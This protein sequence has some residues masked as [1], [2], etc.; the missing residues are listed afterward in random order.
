MRLQR[1]NRVLLTGSA[2]F[3]SS[4]VLTPSSSSSSNETSSFSTSSSEALSSSSSSSFSSSSAASSSVSSS[5]VSSSSL[6]EE[7]S[8]V[9]EEG[10]P[11]IFN[12]FD[13]GSSAINRAVELANISDATL[14]L[15]LYTIA[16]YRGDSSKPTYRLPLTGSL[17]AHGVYVIVSDTSEEFFK[18][19]ADLVSSMLIN[20]GTYPMILLQGEKRLDTLGFPGYQTSWGY[21]S[22][23]VRKNEFQIGRDTF[24]PD[25]WVYYA[26]DEVSHLRSYS[27]PL[28]ED[29][30][31]LGPHLDDSA[32][33]LPYIGKDGLGT[34]GVAEVTVT[35]YGDGDTTDFAY[36]SEINNAGYEDG[37]AFRYQNVDTPETQ[38]GS[39][40]QAQPWGYAA[41]DFTNGILKKA[42]HILVQSIAG[43]ELTET[44]GR[45]LGFVWTSEVSHPSAKDYIL[46]NHEIVVNGYSKVAFSGVATSQMVSNGLSYYSYLLDGNNHAARL[47]LKV[48]GE[49]DP[50]FSY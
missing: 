6:S 1:V 48:H 27:C 50:N 17:S 15:S 13:G 21:K 30:L 37:H 41:K 3:L 5:S 14:D 47:G 33:S 8:Y 19:K 20:N 4:C 39:Y 43:G 7:G 38:H 10:S 36:P 22:S 40:I 28:S 12:E 25:D 42:A 32:F 31:L 49:K 34:G 9:F 11:L 24:I 45:L 46:L 44:Y 18:A 35:Y 29:E 16:I 26:A 23:I 2:L